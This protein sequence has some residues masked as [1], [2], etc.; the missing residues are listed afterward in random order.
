MILAAPLW[1]L[2]GSEY[3]SNYSSAS[4]WRYSYRYTGPNAVT[5]EAFPFDKYTGEQIAIAGGF[6]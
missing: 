6:D 3:F 4:G 1:R 5:D 2:I